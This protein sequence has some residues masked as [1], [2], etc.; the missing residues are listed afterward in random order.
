MKKW[1][2]VLL[3]LTIMLQLLSVLSPGIALKA[4]AAGSDVLYVSPDGNDGWSGTIDKPLK[5]LNAAK[6]IVS[7][8]GLTNATIYLREGT[9]YLDSTLSLTP[10]DN[11]ITF[12]AYNNENVVLSGAYVISNWKVEYLDGRA[13]WTSDI[14]ASGISGDF[15]TLYGQGGLLSNSRLPETGY[16]YASAGADPQNPTN[17]TF[18]VNKAFIY[19][20]SDISDFYDYT[21]IHVRLFHYWVDEYLN[22]ADIDTANK[23]VSLDRG[24]GCTIGADDAYYLENVREAFDKPGE[25]YMDYGAYKLYYI[26][27]ENE[28]ITS[29]SVRAG[30]LEKLMS[31]TG[32][33]GITFNGITFAD[34]NWSDSGA[35][36][37]QAD[38][39][40]KPCIE[41]RD[42]SGISFNGCKFKNIGE[43]CLRISDG[44]SYCTVN[45][46]EFTDIGAHAVYI[47]G[48][49]S[50]TNVTNHITVTDN[51]IYNYGLMRPMSVAVFQTYARYSDIS[52]NEIHHGAYTAISVG[53]TWGYTYTANNYNTV[54][55]N[56]IYDIGHA[57]LSDMG[58]IYLLGVTD[59]TEVSGNVVSDVAAGKD[60][61]TYGGWG[62]YLDEGS[63]NVTVK[64]NL[65]YDCDS[66]GFHQHYGQVNTVQNNIFAFNKDAQV[67][68]SRTTT[69]AELGSTPVTELYLKNNILAGDGQMMY[70]KVSKGRFTDSQNL[71]YDYL[72]SKNQ[73]GEVYSSIEDANDTK[74]A[75]SDIASLGYYKNGVFA[76]PC[77]LDPENRNFNF[78][79]TS[80]TGQIGFTPYDFSNVGSQT[81]GSRYLVNNLSHKKDWYD[82]GKWNEYELAKKNA[83]SDRNTETK[84][85][86]EQAYSSLQ[87]SQQASAS[88]YTVT[89]T[90][91]WIMTGE[92]KKSLLATYKSG[93]YAAAR[94]NLFVSSV[95]SGNS[96]SDA[97]GSALTSA[98]PTESINSEFDVD[99]RSKSAAATATMYI[100]VSQ[101]GDMSETDLRIGGNIESASGQTM[102]YYCSLAAPGTTSPVFGGSGSYTSGTKT[103]SLSHGLSDTPFVGKPGDADVSVS[104][105]YLN[106]TVTG[107]LYGAVPDKG[108]AVSM[109]IAG[110]VL[111][112]RT[113]DCSKYSRNPGSHYY[114]CV[115]S[116]IDLT[117]VG[118]DKSV[119]RTACRSAVADGRSDSA[120]TNALAVL[121]SGNKTQ[122]E[123]D[124]A[125]NSL[126][127]TAA[128]DK[129]ALKNAID[130]VPAY[131]HP[132]YTAES[133]NAYYTAL[134]NGRNIYN[135]PFAVQSDVDRAAS[136]ITAAYG[137]LTDCRKLINKMSSL[138]SLHEEDYST[139]AW[140]EFGSALEEFCSGLI[141]S[142]PDSQDGLISEFESRYNSLLSHSADKQTVYYKITQHKPNEAMSTSTFYASGVAGGT[143][144]TEPELNFDNKNYDNAVNYDQFGLIVAARSSSAAANMYVDRSLYGNLS[145]TLLRVGVNFDYITAG[146]MRVYLMFADGYTPTIT[147]RDSKTVN[148]KTYTLEVGTYNNPVLGAANGGNTI[149]SPPLENVKG[150]AGV[151]NGPVPEAGET[152]SFRLAACT[153]TQNF[154][155]TAYYCTNSFIDF[156]IYGVDKAQLRELALDEY[157][158]APDGCNTASAEYAEYT[159]ALSE[160]RTII[161]NDTYAQNAIDSSVQRLEHAYNALKKNP[162]VTVDFGGAE[163]SPNLVV[164]NTLS[165]NPA[166]CGYPS[167]TGHKC[168]YTVSGTTVTFTPDST[169]QGYAYLPL[170]LNVEAG[171][172]YNLSLKSTSDRVSFLA[173]NPE[174][175][176]GWNLFPKFYQF[177]EQSFTQQSDGTYLFTAKLTIADSETA[178]SA[179]LRVEEQNHTDTAVI[180]DIQ[181][182]G[183]N[184]VTGYTGTYSE[185]DIITLPEVKKYGF[186]PA[187]WQLSDGTILSSDEYTVGDSDE[188]VTALWTERILY[189]DNAAV[190]YERNIIYGI[191]PALDSLSAYLNFREP[192]CSAV[193]E[194]A[195]AKIG[196]GTLVKVYDKDSV[197]KETYTVVLFGDVNGD[198]W[199]DGQDATIV[200][201]IA[202]GMLSE[203]DA[204]EA[205]YMAA[206]CSHDGVIDGLDVET[207]QQAGV[208]LADV[209]QSRISDGQLYTSSAYSEYLS[210]IDQ[211]AEAENTDAEAPAQASLFEIILSCLRTLIEFIYSLFTF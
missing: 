135:D 70:Q 180:S 32:C 197:L 152:V 86:L 49:N 113:S 177:T 13:V 198:G 203:A 163:A 84:A 101:Y 151:I 17:A 48:P 63:K 44:C 67:R 118:V 62:I 53:W 108:E 148:G 157:A 120:V 138:T 208:L 136:A 16:Y 199:Y 51:Y 31:I 146:S 2:S 139:Y 69:A 202:N 20:N 76:D 174:F 96:I 184:A 169:E 205:V 186:D 54:S 211:T 187:G 189:S 167:F 61:S 97:S 110:I 90:A 179:Y 23:K 14:D 33:S 164:W 168:S 74:K 106:K 94:T 82:T 21:H 3:C 80:G 176:G 175:S 57:A 196:T 95:S 65:V 150:K 107:K 89:N 73:N 83:V 4:A 6:N 129:T 72:Y 11:N 193:Y 137:G 28:T 58:G 103:Y 27:Y 77:F 142:T 46:C 201:C 29:T 153:F 190:D 47:S 35:T 162:T 39:N 30:G 206:D 130:L 38:N 154:S 181:L 200:S 81:F 12:S 145:E 98:Y 93:T 7:R 122:A 149:I 18:A 24:S 160:A 99:S 128:A 185:G 42:S 66:Q 143:S 172:T 112:Q 1:L 56:L 178:D 9:Y 8:D 210:L 25:W 36:S 161:Y 204:G 116:Y 192:G 124:A 26:P 19:R 209:D 183:Q 55:D 79:G 5:T 22:I 60:A 188:T 133:W 115:N 155:L 134:E 78:T 109:R 117:L 121:N 91:D 92:C 132:E 45:G 111:I 102:R 104:S 166:D 170:T 127:T 100:D 171:K 64:N 195:F 50:E 131:Y 41:L 182:T 123:I 43:T 126:R 159:A 156:N 34:T 191:E 141:D 68:S 158:S 10:A 207:L 173:Y 147:N 88:A 144:H 59:W 87:N 114:Y 75:K 15:N 52:H 165:F 71:Y 194:K 40:E 140:L 125:V 119:L 37:A 105:E 85:K